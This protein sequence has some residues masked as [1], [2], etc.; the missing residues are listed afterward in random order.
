MLRNLWTMIQILDEIRFDP[1]ILLVRPSS[2]SLLKPE[3]PIFHMGNSFDENS[4]KEDDEVFKPDNCSK[5]NQSENIPLVAN[6]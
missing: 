2:M 3:R 1:K 4:E 5:K 6:K